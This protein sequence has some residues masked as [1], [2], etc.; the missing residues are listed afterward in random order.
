ML[1]L[2]IKCI[3]LL[4]MSV[5]PGIAEKFIFTFSG[6][7]LVVEAKCTFIPTED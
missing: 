7:L 3:N 5:K 6:N 4:C 1:N 2:S